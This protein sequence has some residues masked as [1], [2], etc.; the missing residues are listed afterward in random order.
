MAVANR[1]RSPFFHQWSIVL[2]S[3]FDSLCFLPGL[4]NRI[5][6]PSSPATASADLAAVNGSNKHFTVASIETFS[7]PVLA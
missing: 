2:I 1:D 4:G 6:G 5:T 7:I 3:A